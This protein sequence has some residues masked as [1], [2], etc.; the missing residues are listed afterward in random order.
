M[1][2][3]SIKILV[4]LIC[5]A[6]LTGY[7]AP[8]D[9]KCLITVKKYFEK[10]RTITKPDDKK[11]YYLNVSIQTINRPNA[12]SYS[13]KAQMRIL[14]N[15]KNFQYESDYIN[16]Y[17]DEKFIYTVVKSKKTIIKNF[18]T[19]DKAREEQYASIIDM[20]DAMVEYASNAK[21]NEIKDDKGNVTKIIRLEINN[22]GQAFFKVNEITFYIDVETNLLKRSIMNYI[23][24]Q[25][26]VSQTIQFNEMSFD[27]KKEKPAIASKILFDGKGKV[28]NRYKGFKFVDNT[29]KK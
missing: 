24:N 28:S 5:Y 25:P 20:Q 3:L 15:K 17:G 19:G 12:D 14:L 18:T 22:A 10:A 1:N 7:R 23:I 8:I 9:P 2:R 4:S 13:S 26:F 6:I 21:C 11:T 16:M 27:Y 29:K